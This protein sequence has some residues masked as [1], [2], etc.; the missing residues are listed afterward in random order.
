MSRFSLVLTLTVLSICV[1]S[2]SLHPAKAKSR[3]TSEGYEILVPSSGPNKADNQARK[4]ECAFK[5]C[6]DR[7]AA[8]RK[9]VLPV[10]TEFWN[11]VLV[12]VQF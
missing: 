2:I 12:G 9:R 8:E 11:G 5:I 3:K 6:V 4:S 1:G 10:N 7:T